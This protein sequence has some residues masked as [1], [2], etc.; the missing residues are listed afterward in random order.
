MSH[1]ERA[2]PAL[3]IGL[4]EFLLTA[5]NKVHPERGRARAPATLTGR[6]GMPHSRADQV[7]RALNSPLSTR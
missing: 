3:S 5:Q 4:R 2:G 7:T 1:R 6:P